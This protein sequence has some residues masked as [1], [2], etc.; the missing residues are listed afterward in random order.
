M[1]NISIAEALERGIE[2]QNSGELRVADSLYTSILK[3]DPNHPDANH[4]LGVIACRIGKP[5]KAIPFFKLALQADNSKPQFWLSLIS[6]RLQLGQNHDARS[7]LMQA[8]KVI[9]DPN[10]QKKLKQAFASFGSKST[11][12]EPKQSEL[13]TIL[14]LYNENSF[15][16]AKIELPKL[17]RKYPYSFTINNISGAVNQRL[18]DM[19]QA[20][21][22]YQNALYLK[23]DNPDVLNNLG[24]ALMKV[25]ELAQAEHVLCKAINLN[26]NSPA[27]HNNL[28]LVLKDNGKYNEAIERFLFA[29]QLKPNFIDAKIN[30]SDCYRC[31]GK[32]DQALSLCRATLDQFPENPSVLNNLGNIEN[33]LGNYDKA[34]FYFQKALKVNPNEA[35]YHNNLGNAYSKKGDFKKALK[36]YS[37]AIELKADYADAYT[38]IGIAM[39]DLG[40]IKNAISNYKRALEINPLATNVYRNLS[41][42]YKFSNSDELITTMENLLN[43]VNLNTEKKC[44]LHFALAKAYRD[45]GDYPKEYSHL[46][47]GN[48]I[49]K[50]QLGYNIQRD[51]ALFQKLKTG[52]KYL[53]PVSIREVELPCDVTPIFIIGM[54]RSGTT[55][56]E[57]ILSSHPLVYGAGELNDIRRL[58]YDLATVS[59]VPPSEQIKK[60]RI[61]YLE[62]IKTKNANSSFVTDKMPHNFRFV[63]LI[64]AA[65]PEAKII[66]VHRDAKATC[67]SNYQNYFSSSDLGYTNDLEDVVAYFKL[68]EDLMNTWRVEYPSQIY[69][70]NYEKITTAQTTQTK[71]LLRFID[72]PWENA[73]LTPHKNQR[74]VRTISQQQVRKK[75]YSG[76]SK[77]WLRYKK[78]IG[79]VFDVL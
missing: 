76:S 70:L 8:K 23:P 39:M 28:G 47:D 72:L 9:D 2:A 27:A 64:C 34:I 11:S 32:F 1:Q 42:I 43:E 36:S 41:T 15:E 75:I 50:G 3:L 63:P 38:N 29:I 54:P 56:V 35:M 16:K 49:R 59:N 22:Y 71:D 14:T 24:S 77:Q 57:Q 12:R 10:F 7:L 37:C 19:N 62:I 33:D 69:D 60:F 5:S 73:C 65:M 17:F 20:I 44:A 21:K 61:K 52:Q 58:G 48:S 30:L 66:H 46:V 68:Y 53:K 40:E 4:N 51:I 45:L 55:L 67:W 25:G 6:A 79:N 78:M 26:E 18:G 13:R 74:T 31:I